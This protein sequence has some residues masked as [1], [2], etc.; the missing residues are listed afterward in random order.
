MPVARTASSPASI[1]SLGITGTTYVGSG[2]SD[3]IDSIA[4]MGNDLYVGGR[5]RG[6]I[7]G[8]AGP[9]GLMDGF[10]AKIDMTSGNI[11][12][13]NQFG[14]SRRDQRRRCGSPPRR[15]AARARW[16][17]W[18][19]P[20]ARSTSSTAT[21]LAAQTNIHAPTPM[22]RMDGQSYL[23]GGDT[24][25]I[26]IDGKAARTIAI[27][28]DE[29]MDSLADKIRD[30]VGDSAMVSTP[31]ENGLD[32]LHGDRQG[33]PSDRTHLRRARRRR[34]G[35]PWHHPRQDRHPAR[36]RQGCA[37]GPAR[38]QLSA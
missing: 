27:D 28:A 8:G 9:E 16:T 26:S 23:V 19:S 22:P 37:C 17:R 7:T 31:S 29:T 5:T 10:V 14:S 36:A 15:P 30:I 33:R 24:F 21:S 38:R 32:T 18:A 11:T 20:G 25:Q 1:P 35:R 2:D 4:F 13:T 6:S 34:A 12:N 3:Q